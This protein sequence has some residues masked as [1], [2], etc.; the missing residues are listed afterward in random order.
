MC[1]MLSPI[2]TL[3]CDGAI[4]YL[5]TINDVPVLLDCGWN[6]DPAS[7]ERYDPIIPSL[8]VVLISHPYIEFVGALPYIS[9]HKDF[10]AQI[11]VTFPVHKMSQMVMYDSYLSCVQQIFSIDD[12][13]NTWKKITT[14]MHS[15]KVHMKGE[16]LIFTP[17]RAGNCIGGAAWRIMHNMQD[18]IHLPLFNPHVEK[19]VPGLDFDSLQSPAV[20]IMDSYHSNSIQNDPELLC[21]KVIEALTRGG[22]VLIPVD[23]AGS[24]LE[25][26]LLF[27][28]LWEKNESELG[29]YNLIML[30][31]VSSSTVEFAKTC[32]EWMN[33]EVLSKFEGVRD[34]PF[35]FKFLKTIHTLE[36]LPPGPALIMAT[37]CNLQSGFSRQLLFQL[38]G[39]PLN[40][41][42]LVNKP[43]GLAQEILFN[44]VP[45]QV[46]ELDEPEL[47]WN[48]N[49]FDINNSEEASTETAET[50][51]IIEEGDIPETFG[52]KLFD[53]KNFKCFSVCEFKHFCDEYGESM[54]DEEIAL[55]QHENTEKKTSSLT[56]LSLKSYE[57]T[58]TFRLIE[59]DRRRKNSKLITRH[60]TTTLNCAV[61]YL[62]CDFRAS[63]TSLRLTL[64]RLRPKKLVLL[65]TNETSANSLSIY[66]QTFLG[67]SD[68]S[69]AKE[70]VQLIP[71]MSILPIKI[72]EEF[73][74]SL[75]F[76]PVD[77]YEVALIKGKVGMENEQLQYNMVEGEKQR[78]GYF[79][80]KVQLGKIK[81][82][83]TEKGYNTEF[84]EGKLVINDK[85]WI[86]TNKESG[87]IKEYVIEGVISRDYFDI[88]R[89]LYS[90]HLYI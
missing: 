13:N 3:D 5:V 76:L 54:A 7:L 66:C 8:R 87:E 61:S 35:S 56:A 72:P 39:N 85:V 44:T 84:R 46:I 71:T 20:L 82:L 27:E 89:L 74:N 23:P 52:P 59:E 70:P 51:S 14:L 64:S 31:H 11:Y 53:K 45:N 41:L 34:N 88:R 32:L 37:P 26:M 30:G 86:F 69:V 38:A 78:F 12:I 57:Q 60:L 55:W 40:L 58:I 19:H 25:F 28:E 81:G 15:Q 68:I 10:K 9:K 17:I 80:G 22:S 43:S 18:I 63:G 33:E 21:T 24:T 67:M 16:G 49:E 73:Y 48:E 90:E 83:L 4:S 77:G 42:L 47:D 79:L 65:N 1:A 6:G 2:F 29:M 36:E 75:K 62:L 50:M